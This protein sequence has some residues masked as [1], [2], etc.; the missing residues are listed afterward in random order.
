MNLP[1]LVAADVRRL[2]LS[3]PVLREKDQSLVTSAATLGW[4]G[5]WPQFACMSRW[6]L[7][8]NLPHPVSL[9]HVFQSKGRDQAHINDLRA[10]LVEVN[11]ERFAVGMQMRMI[12]G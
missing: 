1:S 12:A 2:T 5:S 11:K 9:R 8:M 4:V 10:A 3:Q 6:K 7:P